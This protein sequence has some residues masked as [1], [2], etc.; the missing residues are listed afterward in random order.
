MKVGI[1]ALRHNEIRLVQASLIGA[2]FS[3]TLFG[4]SCCFIIGGLCY[5]VQYFSGTVTSTMSFIMVVAT[6]SMIVPTTIH[7]IVSHVGL[8]NHDMAALSHGS[9]IVL[10][11]IYVAYLTFQLRTHPDFFDAENAHDEEF[12]EEEDQ[13]NIWAA[14]LALALVTTL[15]FLCAHVLVGNTDAIVKQMHSSRT[16]IGFILIP[17]LSNTA[18][19][20][21]ALK[22]ALLDNMELA[23]GVAIGSSLQITLFVAPLLVVV[24]WIMDRHLTLSFGI[25]ESV[26][27]LLSS[28]VMVLILQNGRSNYLDGVLCLGLCIIIAMTFFFFANDSM[29]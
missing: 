9:A 25:L 23:I 2:V 10:L 12:E 6:V 17:F 27:L 3:N 28:F 19:N 21:T 20:I 15:V 4:P 13:L 11:L 26:V 5:R 1:V 29:V 24:G 7:F 14:I 22:V 16:F 8:Q 18:D